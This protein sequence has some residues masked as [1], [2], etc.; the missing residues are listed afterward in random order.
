[1]I[2]RVYILEK[3]LYVLQTFNPFTNTF[4]YCNLASNSVVILVQLIINRYRN[5]L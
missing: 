3:L 1:M 4:F 2:K 5:S